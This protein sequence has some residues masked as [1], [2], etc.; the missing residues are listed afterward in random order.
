MQRIFKNALKCVSVAIFVAALSG[1]AKNEQVEIQSANCA[2]HKGY[3]SAS[4][5]IN[6][7]M[8]PL[9]EKSAKKALLKT[10]FKKEDSSV[11]NMRVKIESKQTSNTQIGVIK[12]KYDNTLSLEIVA[13]MLI[14]TDKGGLT[15][16]TS[17]QN[18]SLNLKSAPIADIG[19]KSELKDSEVAPFVEENVIT[20][21]N[22]LY[23]EVP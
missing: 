11:A 16:L 3:G 12:D 22:N 7:D 23:K 18:A 1:C 8:A 17:K 10:C 14:P 19:D 2:T 13:I 20:A 15:T 5:E 9:V 21:L 6:G 4:F